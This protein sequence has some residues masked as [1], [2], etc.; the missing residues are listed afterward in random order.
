MASAI[1]SMMYSTRRLCMMLMP[2]MG[3]LEK[4]SGSRAQCMAQ[5]NVAPIP[6]ASQFIFF[7]IL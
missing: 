3:K 1:T 6:Q 7:F 5:A 2:N 4:K